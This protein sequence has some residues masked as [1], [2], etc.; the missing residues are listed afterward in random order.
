MMR[1]T[2][3]HPLVEQHFSAGLLDRLNEVLVL[4]FAELKPVHV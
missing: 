3:A 4:L 1:T 2:H